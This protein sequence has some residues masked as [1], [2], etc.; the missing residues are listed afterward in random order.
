MV[1]DLETKLSPYIKNNV[2]REIFKFDLIIFFI[3][4]ESITAFLRDMPP[5]FIQIAYIMVTI[6][7][8]LKL[9][10]DSTTLEKL[11]RVPVGCL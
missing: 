9:V 8:W 4:S 7:W 2:Y 11:G 10:F 3:F 5:C 6:F 1:K